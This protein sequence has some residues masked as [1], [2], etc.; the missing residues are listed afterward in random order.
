MPVIA[1]GGLRPKSWRLRAFLRL[2]ALSLS[3]ARAA[4]GNLLAE[5]HMVWG[6]PFSFTAW[7]GA[8]QMRRYARTPPHATAMSEFA[9]LALRSRFHRWEA[10]DLP[11][12][13]EALAV[14]RAAG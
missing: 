6:T 4:D 7:E 3:Q 2:S 9:R 5:V 14:W 12:W 10:V 8:E 11:D 13:P 1:V